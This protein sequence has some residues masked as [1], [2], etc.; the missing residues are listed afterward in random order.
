M[1]SP[2][3]QNFPPSHAPPILRFF[4]SLLLSSAMF[5][6][7]TSSSTGDDTAQEAAVP[8]DVAMSNTQTLPSTQSDGEAE[9]NGHRHEST[10]RPKTEP[11]RPAEP[12]KRLTPPGSP[13]ADPSVNG[14]PKP[15]TTSVRGRPRS[16]LL[17]TI[18][19]RGI[20]ELPVVFIHG[21]LHTREVSTCNSLPPRKHAGA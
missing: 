4:S 6:T 14:K 8:N 21:D 9:G 2:C 18:T 3:P 11:L 12:D 10:P 7:E 1:L 13:K 15:Q 17:K 16:G 20:T 5:I 19:P